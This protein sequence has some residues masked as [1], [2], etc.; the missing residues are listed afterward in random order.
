MSSGRSSQVGGLLLGRAHEVLDVVEVD[1]GQVARPSVGIGFLSNSRRPLRRGLEHPLR[2]VLERRDVADDLLGEPAARGGAGGVGVGPAVLVGAEALELRVAWPRCAVVIGCPSIGG[3]S[4][5][6]VDVDRDGSGSGRAWCRRARRAASVA[7]RW[8]CTPSSRA[9]ASV[10]AS[11]SCGNSR[12][13]VLHRAV[14]LAELDAGRGAGHRPGAGGVA[15]GG[16]RRGQR[17]GAGRRRPCPAASTTSGVALLELAHPGS[18][19]TA[20][21]RPAPSSSA[22][23]RSAEAARS[24]YVAGQRAVAGVG[25]DV[26]PGRTAAAARRPDRAPAQRSATR[27]SASRASRCR[28]TAAG[29]SPRRSAEVGGGDRARARRRPGPT[30]SRVRVVQTV[31]GAQPAGARRATGRREIHNTSVT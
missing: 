21:P 11:H 26:G 31:R 23:K 2:L 8:T 1:A 19:R 29:V 15:V 27:P 30:R 5:R 20:R 4:V 12:G 9:N 13:D 16:Q 28:R 7:R 24:S 10:S 22:R 17:L 14:P 18:R 3:W 6:V 25:Q